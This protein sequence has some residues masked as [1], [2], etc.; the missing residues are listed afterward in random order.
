[1]AAVSKGWCKYFFP[2]NNNNNNNKMKFCSGVFFPHGIQLQNKR[3]YQDH[4]AGCKGKVL[5]PFN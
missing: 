3:K 5:F 4:L 1:M 2:N